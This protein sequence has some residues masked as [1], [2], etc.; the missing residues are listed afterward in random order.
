MT[1][2]CRQRPRLSCQ[3]AAPPSSICGLLFVIWYD[4]TSSGHHSLFLASR[5]E[6]G[7]KKDM[8]PPFDSFSKLH[9]SF[10]L[11]L[12]RQNLVVWLHLVAR[13]TRKWSLFQVAIILPEIQSSPI[14]G[15]RGIQMMRQLSLHKPF[16]FEY[17]YG[18]FW[19]FL[20]YYIVWMYS[21]VEHFGFH[22]LPSNTML[23]RTLLFIIVPP[24]WLFAQCK[25]LK[26]N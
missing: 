12:L 5:K 14:K 16:R 26:Q 23:M 20:Q 1:G 2:P 10:D 6:E 19:L 17:L 15:Q 18:L 13:E 4:F 25:F 9:T 24:I 11:C 3:L 22:S 7:A 21:T 8:P